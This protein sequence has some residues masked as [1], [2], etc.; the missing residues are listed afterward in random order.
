MG[1]CGAAAVTFLPP[2]PPPNYLH[3]YCGIGKTLS[4]AKEK[5]GYCKDL[6]IELILHLSF[7]FFHWPAG[8]C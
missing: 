1:L 7:L 3:Y 8:S 5:R 6:L 4:T 2:E